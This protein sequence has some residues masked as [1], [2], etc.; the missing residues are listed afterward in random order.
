MTSAAEYDWMIRDTDLAA[1][2]FDRVWFG[3]QR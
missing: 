2:R 3:M 1:H